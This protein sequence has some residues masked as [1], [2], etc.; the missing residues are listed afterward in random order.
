MR[1]DVGVSDPS[2]TA[3]DDDLIF[4]QPWVTRPLWRDSTV[5][6]LVVVAV[7]V[8]VVVVWVQISQARERDRLTDEFYCTLSGVGPLDRGPNTGELC[9][10]LRG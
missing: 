2:A 6:F 7:V 3:P 10:N 9:V 8:A 4:R 1:F 5:R